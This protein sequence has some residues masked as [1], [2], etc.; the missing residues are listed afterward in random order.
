MRSGQQGIQSLETGIRLFQALHRLRRP[1]TLTQLAALSGMPP[2]KVHRYCVSLIRTG[3]LQQNARGLYGIGPF[4]F[5]FGPAR[6]EFEHRRT[7]VAAALRELVRVTGETAFS[8][9]WG[10][11]GPTILDVED[12]P[13]PISVRPTTRADLPLLNSASGRVFAAYLAS[14]RLGALI[15]VELAELKAAHG[16]TSAAV[17]SRRR[18]FLRQLHDVRKR[19]LARTTGERY[20][21]LNSFSVPIFDGDGAVAFALTS[22]G[23][24]TTFPSAWDAPVARA[25]QQCAAELTR[26]IGGRT[27]RQRPRRLDDRP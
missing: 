12:A 2:G 23:L 8:S 9:A 3:L 20:P 1:A 17:S 6:A 22:F 14:E 19:R 4:G 26:R 16:L 21:G 13:K 24:A 18:T 10:E 7:L 27:P 25:L 11:R 5:Q 15:E